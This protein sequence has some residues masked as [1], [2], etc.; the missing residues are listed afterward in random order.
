MVQDFLQN[1]FCSGQKKVSK[2]SLPVCRFQDVLQKCFSTP[3]PVPEAGLVPG[4]SVVPSIFRKDN[5]VFVQVSS[6]VR[7]VRA[8]RWYR[9]LV[10]VLLSVPGK[11]SRCV[12]VCAF[13]EPCPVFR[14]VRSWYG[15]LRDHTRPELPPGRSG[16]CLRYRQYVL[17]YPEQRCFH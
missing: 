14:N 15:R 8:E 3:Q 11:T 5:P 7:G 4:E 9:L 6:Q 17:S 13:P 2:H 12:N 1:F 16:K 10:Y